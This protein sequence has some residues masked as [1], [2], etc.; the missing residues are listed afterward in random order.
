M[1]S[2]Q[3]R[4]PSRDGSGGGI[5]NRGTSGRKDKYDAR[6]VS[7]VARKRGDDASG[8]KGR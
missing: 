8:G 6:V 4:L 2:L 3:V 7:A 1:M 5:V